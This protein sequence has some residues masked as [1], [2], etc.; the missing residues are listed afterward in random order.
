VK[1]HKE[2]REFIELLNSAGVRYLVVGGYAVAFHGYPRG[3]GDIDFFVER[4]EDNAARI[5]KV[6]G[7]DPSESRDEPGPCGI[8]R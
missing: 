2:W 5:E 8:L 3:T 1:L 6:P 7:F 4:S